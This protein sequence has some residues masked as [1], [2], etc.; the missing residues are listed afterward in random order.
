MFLGEVPGPVLVEVAVA[1]EGAEL[2]D[3]F[4]AVEAPAGASEV[5]V[6]MT[7]MKSRRSGW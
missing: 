2:E 3:G 6:S 1:D 4:G 7:W 5:H